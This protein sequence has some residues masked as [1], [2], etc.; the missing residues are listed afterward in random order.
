MA[1]QTEEV[2][3][4]VDFAPEGFLVTSFYLDVDATEFPA[5]EHIEKSFDSLIHTAESKRKELED[6]LSHEAEQSLRGDLGKIREFMDGFERHDTNGIAIF[7]CTGQDFWQ[8][9]QLPTRVGNRVEFRPHPVVSPIATFLSH[10]KATAILLTDKQSARIFT[11]KEGEV[12]EWTSFE[13]Y[14]PQRSQAGGWSQMRYQR[15]S[16]NW[17]RHHVDHAAE[18]VLRLKQHYPFDWLILGA[19]VQRQADLESDLHPYLKDAVI[20]WINV[21]IDAPAAE[22]VEEARAVREQAEARLID[23]LLDQIQES[24]GA[25][26][27][28]TAGLKG[29]LAALNEQKVHILLVQE[30]FS[31]PGSECSNC[32]LLMAAERDTCAACNERAQAVENVVDLAIQRA[33]ELGSTVEVATEQDKLKPI[34]FIGSVTYY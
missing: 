3:D 2:R 11:M 34:G 9:V 28:G 27:R 22:V 30:N 6:A 33:F 5:P 4:L 23:R 8:V 10:N 15:R 7:S 29:T 21:R 16:D 31:A 1:V 18:L 32:G 17:A 24:A 20:G 12:R 19:E 13:D 26:G 14:V 25:G